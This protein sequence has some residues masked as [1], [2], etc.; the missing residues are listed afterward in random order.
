MRQC[1]KACPMYFQI[2]GAGDSVLAHSSQGPYYWLIRHVERSLPSNC[3]AF[4][5]LLALKVGTS[6]CCA[7]Q[8]SKQLSCCFLHHHAANSWRYLAFLLDPGSC[9]AIH[10]EFGALQSQLSSDQHN[11]CQI[12]FCRPSCSHDCVS[13]KLDWIKHDQIARLSYYQY[14]EMRLAPLPNVLFHASSTSSFSML[15]T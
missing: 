3:R 11:R 6:S 14:Q 8:S 13:L 10:G 1:Q 15:E 4:C 12:P 7:T 2:S 9:M 5:C